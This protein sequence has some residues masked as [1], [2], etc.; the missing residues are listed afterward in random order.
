MAIIKAADELKDKYWI[1]QA[2]F[3]PK[4]FGGAG[5]QIT[6]AFTTAEM[7]Y[8]DTTPGGNK[9]INPKSQFTRHADP[10][11]PSLAVGSKGM[12][13][14]YS[15][16]FDDAATRISLRFGVPAYN[17][18][19]RFLSG[20][21]D[22]SLAQLVNT[23]EVRDGLF[24]TYTLGK[25]LATIYTLP[26]QVYFGVS[27]LFTR[28]DSVLTGRPYSKYYYM[29]PTM[30]L[31]WTAVNTLVNQVAVNMGLV[32]G[33]QANDLV[34][35]DGKTQPETG[36]SPSEIKTLNAIL[37]DVFKSDS[38]SVIDVKSMASRA[39]RLQN[40]YHNVL[41]EIARDE[42]LDAEGY[43]AAVQ[44]RLRSNSL[45]AKTTSYGDLNTYLNAYQ[46]SPLGTEKKNNSVTPVVDGEQKEQLTDEAIRTEEPGLKELLMSELRE[47]SAFVT[48]EVDYN[49]SI[50]ESFSNST[51]ESGLAEQ[52]NSAASSMRDTF[53]NFAGGNV[54]DGLI[55]GA[56][57]MAIGAVK[58]LLA[59]VAEKIGF[60]GLASLG[61]AGFVDIPEV[62]DNATADLPSESYTIRLSTPYGNKMSI[63]TKIIIPMMCLL[64]GALPRS[65]GKSS[66]GPPFLCSLHSQG[67]N[68]IKLGIIDS[69]SIER[70]TSNI[71]FSVDGLPTAVDITF[72]VKNLNN[73][74][75]VPISDSLLDTVTSF[76]F[77][78]EDT[79]LSDYLST[80]SGLDL[81]SQ[82]YMMPR[83]ELAW[84][85]TAA[86]WDNFTSPSQYAMWT[87]NTL[88]GQIVSG[89]MASSPSL[90]GL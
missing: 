55:G 30:P 18:L 23:G 26:L 49:G 85:K 6:K 20:Y 8:Y 90:R 76:S 53:V 88:P 54:G 65:T 73:I 79:A 42:S 45:S 9:S 77:F 21:F 25:V 71:G 47:G 46:A 11:A 69:I 64:A 34:E 22:R 39:Q 50:G 7:K 48:F 4:R 75:H 72:T 66:Y 1:R 16:A 60:G 31:Y 24:S 61:G 44:E 86:N 70:G 57:E 28:I 38:A 56:A 87:A 80:I 14:Y 35:I 13:H 27:Y 63:F 33:Y 10:R 74:M 83:L 52:I 67:R 78:D 32:H 40:Q 82:F 81:Y 58:G 68:D 89:L 51:K 84:A 43:A 19:S 36:L 37:P 29:N 59:G 3:S 5:Q 15:E 17:P 12:G 62:W 2:F 41:D